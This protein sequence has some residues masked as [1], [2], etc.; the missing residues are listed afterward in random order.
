MPPLADVQAEVTR[1]IVAGTAGGRLAVHGRHYEASLVGVIVDR[2][3]AAV[4][5][6]GPGFV[7]AAACDYI[8]HEP[9]SRPCLAEYG[10]SFPKFLAKRPGAQDMHYLEDFAALEWHL[11]NVAVE[12]GLPPITI[13]VLRDR[14]EATLAGTT[15]MLQPGVRYLRAAWNVDDLLAQYLAD[16][17]PDRFELAA[18]DA[19]IEVRGAR[20]N[21]QLTRLASD[22]HAFR[23]TLANG[24]TLGTA[25]DRAG[26]IDRR[27]DPG[28]ALVRLFAAGLVR[29]IA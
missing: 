7:T 6:L 5:L 2:F 3:P 17:A 11:G 23:S 22:E 29:G 27:F 8:R 20:G 12:I 13:D 10:G 19:P 21:V 26:A 24:A 28:S 18:A 9:P 4:W 14:D 15:F 16:A 25:A 1:A